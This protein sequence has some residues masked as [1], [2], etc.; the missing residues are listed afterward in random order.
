MIGFY[1]SPEARDAQIR[2]PITDGE[3]EPWVWRYK[4]IAGW[5]SHQHHDRVD[6]VRETTP[7]GWIPQSKPIWFTEL[8]CAA[9]DKGTNQPNKFLDPKS[10]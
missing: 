2:T 10:S 4:D 5:W 9:I 8:G 1:H 6:G 3:G 7:T